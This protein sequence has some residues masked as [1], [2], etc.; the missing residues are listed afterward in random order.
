M[1]KKGFSSFIVQVFVFAFFVI[2]IIF[3][4][5]LVYFSKEKIAN[6]MKELQMNTDARTMMINFLR[7]PVNIQGHEMTNADLI[8]LYCYETVLTGDGD[9]NQYVQ[10]LKDE[11]FSYFNAIYGENTKSN[12]REWW[13]VE[14]LF[15][16]DP[17]DTD[18]ALTLIEGKNNL[19]HQNS[20]PTN[21]NPKVNKGSQVISTYERLT[22]PVSIPAMNEGEIQLRIVVPETPFIQANN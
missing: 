19:Y 14:I 15:F 8:R 6:E 7:L 1:N 21:R 4:L 13:E 16:K 3:F 5:I 9:G 18:Q 17:S 12:T 20:Y 11:L 22:D 10:P 2:M